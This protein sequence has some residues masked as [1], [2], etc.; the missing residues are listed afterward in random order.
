MRIAIL[1]EDQAHL[2]QLVTTLNHQLPLPG[3]FIACTPFT[4]GDALR[5]AL[6]RE[7]F[8]LVVLD[9]AGCDFDGFEILQWLRIDQQNDIPVL[10]LSDRAAESDVARA[11][12][13]G[14]DDYVSKPFRSLELC[15]RIRRLSN[16][17]APVP[18][19]CDRFDGWTFDRLT[20]SVSVDIP[21]SPSQVFTLTE[22]E[23]RLALAFFRHMGQLVSRSYLLESVGTERD[24]LPS[25]SLDSHVYRLRNKLDL[26]G[27][28]SVRLITV[29]G[30]GYRLE[31][32]SEADMAARPAERAS[33]TA[34]KRHTEKRAVDVLPPPVECQQCSSAPMPPRWA[35]LPICG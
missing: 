4:R 20:C 5:R 18:V 13:A 23:F 30:R 28:K 14:A 31:R 16:R 7:T 35:P 33:S 27:A 1:E 9:W 22:R 21:G 32:A 25:R 29:Y 34:G 10:F 12:S 26:Y 11:L 8:D 19:E 3:E 15:A 17:R 2:H 24:E 6:Q